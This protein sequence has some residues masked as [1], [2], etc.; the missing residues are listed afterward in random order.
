ALRGGHDV[1]RTAPAGGDRPLAAGRAEAGDA[2][3]ADRGARRA[4]DGPGARAGKT[5]PRAR[6]RRGRDKPQPRGRV[7]GRGQDL[8]AAARTGGRR[9]QGWRGQSGP[10]GRR[11]HRSIGERGTAMST[12]DATVE[13]DVEVRSPGA[14]VLRRFI[15]GD[16]AELR[17]VLALALIWLVFYIQEPRFMS[18]VNL[19]NLVLQMTAVGLVSI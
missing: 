19:S 5:A 18:S 10:G 17:V 7:R 6:V 12:A 13:E 15:A 16:L 11:D 3:R 4:P 14:D 9:L 1:G 2:R 8:R